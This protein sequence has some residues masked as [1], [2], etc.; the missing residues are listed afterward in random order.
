MFERMPL[1]LPSVTPDSLIRR[2]VSPPC[3]LRLAYPDHVHEVNFKE[4][5]GSEP[6]SGAPI[7][8]AGIFAGILFLMKS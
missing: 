8:I 6:H 2:D 1:R 7:K 5:K 3:L 4:S